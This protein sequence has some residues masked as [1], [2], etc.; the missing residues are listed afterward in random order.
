ML[1]YEGQLTVTR[2]IS[3]E[4]AEV[5]IER[6]IS[7]EELRAEIEQGREQARIV[8]EREL[9][10]ELD[11]GLVPPEGYELP[12]PHRIDAV[13]RAMKANKIL[14]NPNHVYAALCMVEPAIPLVASSED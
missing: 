1:E 6:L 5:F 9:G 10:V 2:Q 4:E 13:Y 12:P 8:L 3:Y 11:E 7:D 14:D